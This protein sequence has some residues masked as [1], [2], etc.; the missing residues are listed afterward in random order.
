[1]RESNR[2]TAMKVSRI[3]RPGRYGDGLGLWLQVS[4]WSTKAWLFR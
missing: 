4:K 3:D 1:M 2:L